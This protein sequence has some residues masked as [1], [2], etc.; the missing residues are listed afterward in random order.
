MRATDTL[1]YKYYAFISYT[2]KDAEW[3]KRVQR[4]L[5]HYRM[6]ATLCSER[7]WSRTP[8]RPVFFAQTDIQPGPLSAELQERLKAS[9][10]LIVICS[11]NSAQSEWVG[12][13]IEFFHSL[14]RTKNIHF[15]IVDGVPHSGDAKTECFNP[16][17]KELG[18]PEILGANINEK[19]SR[20]PWLNKERAYV[21]LVSKLLNVE[22]DTI[23]KRHRRQFFRR[24]VAWIIGFSIILATIFGII[25]TSRPVDVE[26]GLKEV[27]VQNDNLP[28]LKDAIVTLTLE[29]ETKTDTVK[30]IDKPVLFN[31]IPH[32]YIGKPVH[33]TVNSR[34]YIGIDTT[35][36]LDKKMSLDIRRDPNVYG[37][38]QFD[39]WD[40][41]SNGISDIK[42]EIA[43]YEV[44]SDENGHVQLFV[45]LEKQLKSYRIEAPIPLM[46]DIIS[47]PCGKDYVIIANQ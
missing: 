17:V 11:P 13:E 47:M 9:R 36:N 35:M 19:V 22:F 6:P 5:E 32:K 16:I 2:S 7:G 41:N 37:N 12:R 30:L 33:I 8:I 42:L 31:N 1:Q 45:P 23:W 18:L 28:A 25:I 14:G 20:L 3:G 26:M 39:L 21:Q 15:F 29:N 46:K 10:N 40:R 44:V 27:S 24:L 38:I 4:K 43:G 34:D